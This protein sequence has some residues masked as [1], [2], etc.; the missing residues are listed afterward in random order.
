MDAEKIVDVVIKPG[1]GAGTEI[2]IPNEGDIMANG[3]RQD[4]QC[5]LDEKPH[6]VYTRDGDDLHIT[7]KLD[8]S[9]ALIG[10]TKEILALDNTKVPLTSDAVIQPGQKVRLN[11]RGMPNPETGRRGDLF[12]TYN[13]ALPTSLSTSQKIKIMEAL[14]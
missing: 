2:L 8:L 5:V 13:V 1:C 14:G 11:R 4:I 12:V 9:D 10:F 6:D 3:I 7:V